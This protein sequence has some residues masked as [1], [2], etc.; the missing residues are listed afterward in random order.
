M[1]SQDDSACTGHIT[2][3]AYQQ[4]SQ[5]LLCS[6]PIEDCDYIMI[7]PAA[8]SALETARAIYREVWDD[9]P[10]TSFDM[11]K[12]L[13]ETTLIRASKRR[14]TTRDYLSNPDILR[15]FPEGEL[16]S[17]RLDCRQIRLF[18][19]QSG[20]CTSFALKV[21]HL[22]ELNGQ[23]MYDFVVYDLG[24][25]RFVRCSTTEIVI[26]S[27]AKAIGKLETGNGKRLVLNNKKWF[28]NDS[29]LMFQSDLKKPVC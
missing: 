28:Y 27:S 1:R 7:Q 19:G 26:D 11:V 3:T 24:W 17:T 6:L 5:Y 4:I 20:L 21:V 10:Y 9:G 16:K 14:A 13:V 2:V 18:L 23:G 12:Y 25:H 22:L 29:Q 15:D 8:R